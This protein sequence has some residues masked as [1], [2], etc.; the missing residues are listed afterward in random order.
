DARVSDYCD[1]LTLTRNG[2]CQRG[3]ETLELF[4]PAS[5][6]CEAAD[7]GRL[8]PRLDAGFTQ[9]FENRNGR[10]TRPKRDIGPLL[11]A[12]V[13]CNQSLSRRRQKNF[14]SVSMGRETSGYL[15]RL[16]AHVEGAVSRNSGDNRARTD[17]GTQ[18]QRAAKLALNLSVEVAQNVAKGEACM[19]RAQVVVFERSR[20]SKKRHEFFAA[21]AVDDSA[22]ADD[23]FGHRALHPTEQL[24]RVILVE[25]FN[26]RRTAGNM[27]VEDCRGSP[28]RSL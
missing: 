9:H 2:A 7:F 6:R 8:Q 27:C 12:K 16:A 5:V 3:L 18:Q 21:A 23:R 10:R 13:G 4:L 26:N 22:V 28:F 20:H 19:H 1:E 24:V 15:I 25:F 11:E 14:T 17:S